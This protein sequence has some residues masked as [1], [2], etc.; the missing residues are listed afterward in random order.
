MRRWA[1]AAVL[2]ALAAPASAACGSSKSGNGFSP[3]AGSGSSSGGAVDSGGVRD[4]G[5]DVPTLV[6]CGHADCDGDGYAVPADCNDGD[7]L[8]NPEAFDFAGDKVD[9]DC[10]GKVD[11]PVLECE[12]VP[13][14]PPGTPTDFARAAELCAQNSKTNAGTVFDPLIHAA[15]GQVS[16]LGPGQTLWTSQTKPEQIAIVSS[17]GGNMPRAGRTMF[18]LAN[19]PW[20]A[21]DPRSSMALDP[22]GFHIDD[23]CAAIPLMGMDCTSLTDGTPSGGVNVQDWAELALDVK[24][25]SNVQTVDFDFSFFSSEFNQWWQSA[26]NDAFFVLVTSKESQGQNVAKDSSGLA[27]TINSAFFNLCPAPPGP[28]GLSTDKSAAIQACVGTAGNASQNIYGTLAGTGYDGAAVS[29]ND[30]AIAQNG[31]EYIYGAGTGWLTGRF[32][33]TRGE[34]IQMRIVLMDTFDGLKDS[35]LLFDAL[36][37]EKA[38]EMGGVGR[39]Q[40][41]Q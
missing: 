1:C 16:G 17:F 22:T 20:G 33:V 30:T 41:N 11:D 32:P 12:T 14:Q 7:P 40:P 28:A 4:S 25:P 23:G 39:P 37:W 34:T 31:S 21:A 35:A 6:T 15:W 10:D 13:S 19:G 2:V 3:D 8:V 38:T 36:R 27:V 5:S 18:G 24:I 9:D 26:A 29:G